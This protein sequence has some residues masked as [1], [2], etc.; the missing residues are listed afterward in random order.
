MHFRRIDFEEV[1]AI[2]H[3]NFFPREMSSPVNGSIRLRNEKILFT[4]AREIVNLIRHA[5]VFHFA[6]WR[7]D[8]TEF[9]DARESAHRTDQADVWTF[10]R[11]DRTNAAVMRWM[12]VAHFEPSAFTTK[13]SR[14]ESRQA[15]FVRQ[16][17]ERIGLIHEL[18]KL[19]PAKEIADNCAER[20]RINQLL[21]RHPV[22]IDV[23]QRHAL[24]DQTFGPSKP[25]TALIRQQ[26]ANRAHPTTA[27]VVDV[28]ECALASA[29]IDQ[30]LDRRDEIFVGQNPLSGIDVDPE[31]L[32]DFIAADAPKIVFFRIEKEPFEQSACIRH[33]RRITGTK[34]PVNVLER[35]LLVMGRIFPKRLHDRVIVRNVDHFHL[36]NL[37]RHDLADGRQSQRLERARYRHLAVTNLASEHFGGQLFFVEPLA[38]LQIFNVV[39]KFDD[40]FV[41]PITKR[42]KECGGEKLPAAL[43]PIEINVKKISRIKLHLNPRTA[44]RDDPE[45]VEHFSVHVNGRFKSDAGGAVQLAHHH[46]LS[47]INDERAL[48]RHERDFAHVNLLFLGAFFLPQL[49]RKS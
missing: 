5:A 31:F 45:A 9:I 24:F 13:T 37:E 11:L 3:R 14:A 32:I 17:R 26:F 28:V 43:A 48:R 7:F 6:I 46:T 49:D 19:R 35:F 10:W 36:V 8:K 2:P 12:N 41:R 47:A 16:L 20:L 42:A 15:T 34:A 27:Q 25:N 44:V 39:K 40:F 18:R 30:I 29:Q 4:V 38:Q 22:H 33:G 21:R 1:T 23:E